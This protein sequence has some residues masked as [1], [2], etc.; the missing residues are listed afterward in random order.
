MPVTLAERQNAYSVLTNAASDARALHEKATRARAAVQ[1]DDRYSDQYRAEQIAA[2]E[3][4]QLAAIGALRQQVDAASQTLTTGAQE[5]DQPATDPTAQLAAA[6]LQGQ[7]WARQ[8]PQLDAG[9]RWSDLLGEATAAGDRPAALA[10]A[11]E[12]PNYVITRK[13]EADPTREA[14]QDPSYL[15]V[16][17]IRQGMDV[18]LARSFGDD[19]GTGTAAQ[20][21]VHVAR[22]G[23]LAAAELDAAESAA[24]GKRT[25]LAGAY[26]MKA[27]Q[28][29]ADHIGAQLDGTAPIAADTSS[30][31]TAGIPAA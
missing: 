24:R 26:A 4:D 15:D 17:S 7:A 5:L 1:D 21:R 16:S 13:L 11:A 8:R 6:T 30:A 25:G 22:F 3:R 31:T 10:L 12:V 28:S 9:R 14:R 23:P 18:T 20:A 29:R 2:I 19:K 27:A